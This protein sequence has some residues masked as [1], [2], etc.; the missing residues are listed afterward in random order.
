MGSRVFRNGDGRCHARAGT[1]VSPRRRQPYAQTVY[2]TT[3][4]YLASLTDETLS[5]QIDLSNVGLGQKPLSWCLNALVISHLN[6]MIG[7]ISCLKGL[8]GAKGYPF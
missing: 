8:Q 1:L 6:N 5:R 4:D 7:E 2:T 3:N